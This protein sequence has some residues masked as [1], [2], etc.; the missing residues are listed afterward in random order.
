VGFLFLALSGNARA[1]SEI[2]LK[3]ALVIDG[4]TLIDGTGTAPVP[5]SV[6]VIE[7]GKITSLGPR[8]NARIPAGAHVIDAKGK[9]LVPGLTDS[10]VHYRSWMG[11]LLLN[12]GITT[13]FD[14]GDDTDWILSVRQAERDGKVL[15]PRIFVAGLAITR[16][17]GNFAPSYLADAGT[18]APTTADPA[19]SGPDWARA[20]AKALIAR[21]VDQ[22]KVTADN[23]TAE[24]IGAIADEARKANR[25]MLGHTTDIYTSV[26]NGYGAVTHLWGVSASLM[27]PENR[28]KFGE[29]KIQNPYA[30]IEPS[31]IDALVSF[32]VQHNAS[33][34]PLLVNEH[35]AML[36]ETVEFEQTNYSLYMNPQLRYVPLGN[37][38]SSM[39]FWHKTRSY[40]SAIGSYPY[41]EMLQPAE[42]EEAQRG[43]KNAQEFVR[44][45]NKAGG[46]ILGGTDTGG[47]AIVPGTGLLQEVRLFVDAG[48]TPMQA[49]QTITKNPAE[50][51][52]Q[53]DKVGTLKAGLAGDVVILDANPLSDIRNL[54]KIH[55]VIKNGQVLDGRYHNDYHPEFWTA[56]DDRGTSS[57]TADPPSLSSVTSN[58]AM[59]HGGGP[60]ELTVKGAAFNRTSLVCLNGRPVKTAF[61]SPSELRATVPADRLQTAGTYNVTVTTAWPIPMPGGSGGTSE[62]KTLVIN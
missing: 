7:D 13:V 14:L 57:S 52:H 4:G 53:A 31:K 6:I 55:A 59:V 29:G 17:G 2:N 46:R 62:A 27:T 43:Y 36:P 39:T 25:A 48:L 35:P 51:Y 5:N 10:H 56:S 11:E 24:E 42:L 38:I 1:Q 49:L 58:S 61:V 37:V 60:V 8:A 22:I 54:E 26:G 34:N 45:F 50:F 21:G 19:R 18:P 23:L 30:Y 16:P 12:H 40:S 44:R 28:K 15:M 32:M 9:F 33:V 47:S 41:V 20:A 3:G